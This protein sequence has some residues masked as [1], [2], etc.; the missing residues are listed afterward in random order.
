MS[1]FISGAI[2]VIVLLLFVLN[3]FTAL[4]D[5]G[6]RD[7]NIQSSSATVVCLISFF[8]ILFF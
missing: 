8:T 4:Y 1:F 5:Y 6:L 3:G 2:I 7:I